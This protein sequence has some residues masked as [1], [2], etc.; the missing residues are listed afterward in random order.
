ME[1][2]FVVNGSFQK[3]RTRQYQ[4]QENKKRQQ[5]QC[6]QQGS[7]DILQNKTTDQIQ[8][9]ADAE[10]QRRHAPEHQAGGDI[11]KPSGDT[12]VVYLAVIGCRSQDECNRHTNQ[13]NGQQMELLLQ[14]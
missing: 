5:S 2:G 14:G 13:A 6:D 4:P 1:L 9:Q 3:L 10:T 8:I 12:H 7:D 11:N